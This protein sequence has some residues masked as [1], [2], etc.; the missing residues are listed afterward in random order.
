MDRIVR[1]VELAGDLHLFAD[2][3]LG[4]LG[5]VE[6]VTFRLALG[7]VAHDERVVPALELDD[8]A[9]EAVGQV[10]RLW[11]SMLLLVLGVER[12]W[13]QTQGYGECESCDSGEQSI[14]LEC[15]NSFPFPFCPCMRVSGDSLPR[16]GKRIFG[17]IA[18][19]A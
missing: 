12:R 2:V 8:G 5:G 11:C 4:F 17:G 10:C 18:N 19:I 13:A 6:E 16:F 7:P 15:Q 1:H 3:L 14:F 9:G